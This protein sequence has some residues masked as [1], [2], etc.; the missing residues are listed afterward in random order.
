MLHHDNNLKPRAV[1]QGERELFFMYG[2]LFWGRDLTWIRFE[3]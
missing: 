3:T 2:F 1:G